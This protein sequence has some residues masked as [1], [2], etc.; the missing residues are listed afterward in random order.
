[1]TDVLVRNLSEEVVE[2]LKVRARNR[3]R[4]LQQELKL[5]LEQS[6]A[7]EAVDAL[8][9]ARKVRRRLARERAK[10]SDSAELVREDRDR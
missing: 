2:K 9:L 5:L 6:V 1:M 10:Q 3:G 4:S 7:A 8:A